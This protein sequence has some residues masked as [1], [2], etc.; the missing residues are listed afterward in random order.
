MQKRFFNTMTM[1]KTVLAFLT[2]N[3]VVWQSTPAISATVDKLKQLIL[4]IELIEYHCSCETTVLP[5]EKDSE[6]KKLVSM[7]GM[8]SSALLAVA[9]RIN[10]PTLKSKLEHTNSS[11]KK[12]PDK[13]T[14]AVARSVAALADIHL[15]ELLSTQLS[16]KI[17][18][19]LKDQIAH[20]E[21]LLHLKQISAA[22]LKASTI[23]IKLLLK[24]ADK[25]LKQRLDQMMIRYQTEDPAFY[26]GYETARMAP[27]YGTHYEKED[28][29]KMA[30]I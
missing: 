14:L 19:V 29:K 6:L 26:G 15:N 21:S 11:L 23:R 13:E 20:Y 3:R 24:Q 2:E 1:L 7:T 9:D 28:S 25:L 18:G 5:Q 16:Q 12:L 27:D 8:V 17:V 30:D 10:N 4:E 22:E